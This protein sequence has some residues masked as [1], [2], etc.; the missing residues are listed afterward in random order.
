MMNRHSVIFFT[1]HAKEKFR[2]L[3]RHGFYISEEQVISTLQSPD[4]VDHSRHPLLFAQ[5][6][7]DESHVLRV[8]YKQEE[9]RKIIITFYPGRRKDYE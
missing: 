9:D 3:E 6:E 1:K 5:G 7:V 2:L 8:V 4:L